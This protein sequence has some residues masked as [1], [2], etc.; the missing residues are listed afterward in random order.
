MPLNYSLFEATRSKFDENQIPLKNLVFCATD[1]A[2]SVLGKQN[3]FIALIKE[4]CSSILALC[5]TSASFNCQKVSFD[6]INH[7]E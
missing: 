7:W 4:L 2:S 5:G 1:G 3:G 6:V